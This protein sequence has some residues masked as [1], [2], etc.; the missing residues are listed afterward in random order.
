MG[1]NAITVLIVLIKRRYSPIYVTIAC[2]AV[3]DAM[4]AITRYAG[5]LM[6][7]S[8]YTTWGTPVYKIFSF[9]FLHSA[10]FHMVLLS[11]IR[12]K[13]IAEPLR[14]LTITCLKVIKLSAFIWML[15]L[16]ACGAYAVKQILVLNGNLSVNV[17]V[18]TEIGFAS[19]TIGLPFFLVV[20][21]QIRKTMYMCNESKQH[22]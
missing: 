12:Y 9:M 22:Q 5:L 4:A 2:L 15:S 14:S 8:H 17:E 18:N 7:L 1:G 11:Y 6:K 3:S 13:F 20:C 19:Y 16:I 10:I 21:F